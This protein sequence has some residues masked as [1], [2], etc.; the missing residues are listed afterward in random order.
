M[1][2]K[3]F[4]S[5]LVI[6]SVLLWMLND[7]SPFFPLNTLAL[8]KCLETALKLATK[9]RDSTPFFFFVILWQAT[10]LGFS[11]QSSIKFL[12]LH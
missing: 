12:E 11:S 8:T 9:E 6:L 2:A 7:W 4:Q 3:G 1:S 10:Q 5:L